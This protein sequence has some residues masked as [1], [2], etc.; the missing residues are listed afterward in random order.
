MA[1]TPLGQQDS[2]ENPDREK[3][4]MLDSVAGKRIMHTPRR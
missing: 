2:P 1:N 3:Q 4:K